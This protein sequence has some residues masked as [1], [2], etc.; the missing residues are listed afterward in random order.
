VK[1]AEGP[2]LLVVA[3]EPSGDRI[4]A[5]IARVARRRGIRCVGMGGAASVA[6]GV[7]LVADIQSSAAMGLSE[8]VMRLPH[9][10]RAFRRLQDAARGASFGAAVLVD[11]V[12][13]NQRLGRWLREQG[14][15][16]LWCVAPQ[17]WAWLPQRR[18]TVARALDCLATILPFEPPLWR[19]VGVDAHYIGHPA[20]EVAL[21]PRGE[22]RRRLGIDPDPP[23]VALLPGS[24][25]HEVRRHAQPMLDAT[26]D[27]RLR[28]AR[29]QARLL[30]AP[31]LDA[32]TRRWLE[33]RARAAGVAV[34]GV[35]AEQ[36]AIEHLPAFDAAIVASG[37]ASLECALAGAL[38]A[39]M[40]R[41]SPLTAAVAKRLVRTPHV[42]L[43]N[44]LLGERVFPELLQESA[45]RKALARAIETLLER[46]AERDHISARLRARLAAR[47]S[48]REGTSAER[49]FHLL[50][51]WIP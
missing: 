26:R 48:I 37:T 49:A 47:E 32:G 46:R 11:Y 28:D 43:P 19:E 12:E 8:V 31:W 30:A 39:I 15:R 4:A 27:L 9:V 21:P 35:D 3:G 20:L 7:E 34:V 45:E 25:P 33:S 1:A 22:A 2:A 40:Y 13:F 42:A 41:L 16:V 24:R 44:V 10:V 14:V 6:A 50:S 36:G 29:V 18:H 17:V 38:P 23:A 5:A 51:A